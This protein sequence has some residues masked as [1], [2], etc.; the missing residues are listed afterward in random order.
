MPVK[1][2]HVSGSEKLSKIEDSSCSLILTNKH[3]SFCYISGTESY[4]NISRYQ[5]FYFLQQCNTSYE[6]CYKIFKTLS[7]I[8]LIG[9]ETTELCY[10]KDIPERISGNAVERFYPGVGN[11]VAYEISGFSGYIEIICDFREIYDFSDEGR[12]YRIAYENSSIVIEYIKYKSNEL[13][14]K[15]YSLYC[16]I[17]GIKKEDFAKIEKWE[18]RLYEADKRRNSNP[19]KCYVFN[20]IRLKISSSKTI[21]FG[22]G[23][24]KEEAIENSRQIRK[25]IAYLKKHK[26]SYIEKITRGSLELKSSCLGFNSY[27]LEKIRLAY[28]ESVI[29]LD[30]MHTTTTNISGFWAGLPWFHQFWSRD[31]AISVKALIDEEMYNSAKDIL[32]RLIMHINKDGRIPN[33]FPD[34]MLGSADSVGWSFLRIYQLITALKEKGIIKEYI[35]EKE[36]AFIKEQLRKSIK[37]LLSHSSKNCFITNKA[38]ETWMDTG[39]KDD[40]REGERIEIQALTLAMYRLMC[41]L[42]KLGNDTKR[43]ELY[44]KLTET[45]KEIVKKAFWQKPVLKDSP[46]D[47]TCRPN[48][49]IAYYCYPELLEKREWQAAFDYALDRLW[50]DWGNLGGI[51]TIDKSHKYF[52]KK[53]TG[54][55]NK[56]YHR[57]DSWYWISCLTAICLL[58][59]N[60][61][62]YME[63][64]RKLLFASCNEI[65]FKG[66]IGFHSELSSACCHSS[67]GCAAQT[68][69]SA[70]FIELISELFRKD[71]SIINR[72]KKLAQP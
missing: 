9:L 61:R 60:K 7:E 12:I 43:L 68:W 29:A 33:R 44:K 15:D 31:E 64:I 67:E 38:L 16:V 10:N 18:K 54:E 8:R 25:N 51:A 70:M 14:E 41:L 65:L 28:K 57:G 37:G 52:S 72:I 62:K 26:A 59:L 6:G 63:Y 2:S 21:T 66:A 48:I 46:E 71:R 13:Q 30:S 39:Y 11:S 53:Y 55:D 47:T 22:F 50:L 4:K 17:G 24:T 40:T 42:C 36:L 27:E 23:A 45:T 3:G 56:S 58:R 1:I 20:A 49:F 19:Y 69:S 35:S 32:F 34:A 5:G